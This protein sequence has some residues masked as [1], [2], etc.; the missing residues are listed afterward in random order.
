MALEEVVGVLEVFV[1]TLEEDMGGFEEVVKF[2]KD[3][4]GALKRL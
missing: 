1:G 4:V 2:P 3:V